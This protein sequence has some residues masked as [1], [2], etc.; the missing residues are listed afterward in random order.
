MSLSTTIKSAALLLSFGLMSVSSY[1][2]AS[3]G[4]QGE[5]PAIE[6]ADLDLAQ[7]SSE[8]RESGS[9]LV[10]EPSPEEAMRM[11]CFLEY[12][13]CVSGNYYNCHA[14]YAACE[15]M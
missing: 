4:E 14:N 9:E 7:D 6:R 13:H 1:A 2:A 12:V 8:D 5:A 15:E 10:S 11:D 3:E